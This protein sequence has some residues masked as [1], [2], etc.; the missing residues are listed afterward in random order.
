MPTAFGYDAED[1]PESDHYNSAAVQYPWAEDAY[2]MFPSPY[3]HFP[4][5]PKAGCATKGCWTSRWR[6]AGTA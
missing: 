2:F 1:P 4:E 5:P 6:S 3:L